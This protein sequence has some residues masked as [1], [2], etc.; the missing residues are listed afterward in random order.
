MLYNIV[1]EP[2][3][4]DIQSGGFCENRLGII[5][6]SLK[7]NINRQNQYKPPSIIFGVNLEMNR[8]FKLKIGG[9]QDSGIA[10]FSFLFSFFRLLCIV[11]NLCISMLIIILNVHSLVNKKPKLAQLPSNNRRSRDTD[12]GNGLQRFLVSKIFIF[13]FSNYQFFITRNQEIK[14]KTN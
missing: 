13:S 3:T 4:G 9:S 2:L 10:H 11:F 8:S 14:T 1:W 6:L 12:S 7:I 5:R